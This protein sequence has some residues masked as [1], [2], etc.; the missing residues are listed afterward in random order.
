MGMKVSYPSAGGTADGY[1]ALPAGAD[2]GAP[3]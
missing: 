3:A 2:P 1:L